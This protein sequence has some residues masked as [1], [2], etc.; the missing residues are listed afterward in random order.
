MI[1]IIFDIEKLFNLVI[2]RTVY[3]S[4]QL[5]QNIVKADLIP[6]TE[7]D[8][9][10][11]YT[12]LQEASGTTWEVLATWAADSEADPYLF[13][14]DDGGESTSTYINKVVFKLDESGHNYIVRDEDGVEVVQDHHINPQFKG[15]VSNPLLINAIQKAMVSFVVSDWLRLKGFDQNWQIEF[16]RHQQGLTDIRRAMEYRRRAKTK[17][18][19]F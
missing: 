13:N 16:A 11:F 8:R 15:G 2:Q 7:D 6:M 19:T 10:L 14:L 3:F 18:R 5:D 12:L 9:E 4:D 17:Y 1:T